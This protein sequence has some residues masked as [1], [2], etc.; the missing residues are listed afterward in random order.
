MATKAAP[1]AKPGKASAER[2][3]KQELRDAMVAHFRKSGSGKLA[4]VPKGA[5][6]TT[7]DKSP[8]RTHPDGMFP[9]G[10]ACVTLSSMSADTGIPTRKLGV[11]L[12]AHG[13]QGWTVR[14]PE[15]VPSSRKEIGYW[16]GP[17]EF[18]PKDARV[19]QETPIRLDTGKAS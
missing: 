15:G 4:D 16:R 9:G 17:R 13:F 7:D 8:N 12:R 5:P 14:V 2:M 10:T 19:E 11:A 6:F 1:K 18:V 3:T